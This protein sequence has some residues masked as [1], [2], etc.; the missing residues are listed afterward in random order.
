MKLTDEMCNEQFAALDIDLKRWI[1]AAVM[2]LK[3]DLANR[4]WPANFYEAADIV[5]EKSQGLHQAAYEHVHH[6]KPYY[7][8]HRWALRTAA[9]SFRFLLNAP[10]LPFDDTKTTDQ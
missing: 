4:K 6:Q 5:Q 3:D 1:I 9:A 8:M 10:E 7:S 2:Q